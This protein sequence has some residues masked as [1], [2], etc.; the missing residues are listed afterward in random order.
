MKERVRE[1]FYK[2]DDRARK[3]ISFENWMIKPDRD[4]FQ[5]L[6][7]RARHKVLQ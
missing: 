6:D 1:S 5:K 4:S 7:D 2:P 3:N